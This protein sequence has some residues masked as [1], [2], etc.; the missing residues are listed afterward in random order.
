MVTPD[1]LSTAEAKR[2]FVRRMFDGI[3]GTYDLLNHLLS[4]GA[5]IVWRRQAVDDLQVM[6][7]W[8]IL[9][10]ATGTGDLA[11]EAAGR[12]SGI[13]VI[14]ADISR[15]MLRRGLSK[16]C[17]RL[18]GVRFLCGDAERLPFP[19]RAFDGMTIGFGIRNVADVD[20][21]LREMYRVLKP[22]ARL[23]VLEFSRPRTVLLS[24]LYFLYF[25]CLL[26]VIDRLISGHT[27]AYRYLYES[28][29]R[30]PEG[31]AFLGRM[32]QVGFT[33]LRER[34]LTLGI[35]TAYLATRPMSDGEGAGAA[36]AY[37]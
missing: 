18:A 5:D 15:P 2:A 11:F 17:R 14:G 33:G 9:D 10:L 8:R 29:M 27:A 25:K 1:A 28:V 35:A 6:D 4:G 31:Q 19:D 26:P 12:G 16:E 20:V 3:A 13:R 21:G 32:E 7:G 34:R 37:V 30:F 24:Q 36:G 23:A 22:G